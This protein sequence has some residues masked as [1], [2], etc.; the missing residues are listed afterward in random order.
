MNLH[1]N[2]LLSKS[3]NYATVPY[4]VGIFDIV[5]TPYLHPFNVITQFASQN[6]R[7]E[8]HTVDKDFPISVLFWKLHRKN[9]S[10]FQYIIHTCEHA[11]W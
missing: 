11:G 6:L 9:L 10:F 1:F 4:V 3:S 8:G 2:F 5:N 7:N